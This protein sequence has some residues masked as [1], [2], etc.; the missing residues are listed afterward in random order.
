MVLR[1][2]RFA[3]SPACLCQV[4]GHQR[5]PSSCGRRTQVVFPARYLVAN[6]P[7]ALTWGHARSH[8]AGQAAPTSTAGP[9]PGLDRADRLCR[10]RRGRPTGIHV[11]AGEPRKSC[12]LTYWPA[13]VER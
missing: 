1:F 9:S 3:S 10:R 11:Q 12:R 6:G 4:L 8:G 5:S 2:W 7:T 13:A